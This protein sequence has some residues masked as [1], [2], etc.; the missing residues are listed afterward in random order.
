MVQ[1]VGEKEGRSMKTKI[2]YTDEPMGEL[3]VIKDF[4]PPPDQLVLKEEN[5]KITISLKKSSVEFFKK[6]AQKR[7]TP[8]QKLSG[9]LSIGMPPSIKRAPDPSLD[10]QKNRDTYHF[11]MFG[12]LMRSHFCTF[13]GTIIRRSRDSN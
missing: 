1:A 10:T 8:Y 4:L 13:Q 3:R 2:R 11:L 5:V 12:E 7:R 9:G 6:E